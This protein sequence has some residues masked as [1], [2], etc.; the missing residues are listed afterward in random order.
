MGW[1]KN[2]IRDHVFAVSFFC[3][4]IF[5]PFHPD[6]RLGLVKEYR[7]DVSSQDLSS[8]IDGKGF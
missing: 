7:V 3:P 5:L 6:G 8:K 1:Q 4:N 2:E